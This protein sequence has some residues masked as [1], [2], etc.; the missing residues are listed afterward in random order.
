M[1]GEGKDSWREGLM[2]RKGISGKR[3]NW[4]NKGIQWPDLQR[5]NE[6]AA[7]QSQLVSVIMPTSC[8][9]QVTRDRVII[10]I[11]IGKFHTN[12]R[13]STEIA[14]VWQDRPLEKIEFLSAHLF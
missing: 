14:Y 11:I 13:M 1:H 4:I 3:E 5:S 9:L 7:R 6:L 10:I 8:H 12:L 2:G